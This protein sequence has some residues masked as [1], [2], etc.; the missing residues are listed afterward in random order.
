LQILNLTTMSMIEFFLG[1][2]IA[3]DLIVGVKNKLI[4]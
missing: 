1:V 3:K 4:W 2:D